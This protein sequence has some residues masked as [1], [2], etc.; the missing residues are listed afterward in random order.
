MAA[1]PDQLNT[2]AGRVIAGVLAL[3]LVSGIYFFAIGDDTETKS[4]TAHFPR[5]VSIYP[6]SDVRI[7]GVNIGEVTEVVPEG[8]SVRVDIAYDAAYDVPSDAKAVIVTPTL[9]ADRFVQLTPAIGEGDEVMADGADIPL[10]DTGVPVELDRIYASLRDLSQ[11]LG[12]NGVNKDGTLDHVLEAGAH[13]LDGKGELGNDMLEQ[14]SAAAETFGKGSGPLFE[15]VTQ[16]ATVTSTLAENDGLV[17]AFV[18]DLAGVSAQL[19]GERTEIRQA[20][21]SVA[22]AVGTVKTFVGKNRDALV[23]DI[24]KLTRVMQTIN[25]EKSSLD[26]A[27]RVAPTAI[28]NL[29]LA[30][31]NQTGTIGSRIGLSGNVWDADRLLCAIVQNASIGRGL[32]NLACGL[33]KTLLEP[34]EDQLPTIPP[35]VP[36]GA[37]R[38]QSQSVPRANRPAPRG[39][40]ALMG[41][42]GS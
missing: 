9:V 39:L 36:Q 24:E 4:V 22:D 23:T 26:T 10:P 18:K 42:G 21:A 30:F 37:Q 28:G 7:L 3:V 40:G 32:A 13:A 38:E 41:G 15:T 33:F 20:L 14:L 35:A 11:A 16:L 27:L 31:N 34:V 29:A 19:S 25:S 6:G 8:N 2:F 17:R 1:L 5:A 12:P